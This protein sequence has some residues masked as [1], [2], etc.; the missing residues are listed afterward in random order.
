MIKIKKISFIILIL[1]ISLTAAAS[2]GPQDKIEDMNFRNADIVDVLRAIAEVADVNL[3][4]DSQVVGNIT[5][6]L[7][8]ITFE[9]SLDLITK[10]RGLDYKWDN[11][12]VVVAQPEK[13]DQIYSNLVTE[14][15]K[16]NSSDFENIG[17]IVKEIFPETLI[18]M[19]IS[20]RQFIIKGESNRVEE[21]K[22][23]INRLDSAKVLKGSSGTDFENR[24]SEETKLYSESYTVLNADLADLESKL[25]IVNSNLNFQVNPLTET[26]T[27]SG[28]EESVKSI[29]SMAKTYDQSLEPE[30]RKMRVDYID[31]AQITEIINK[32]YPDIQLH[33]NAKR[34]EIIINGAKN[35][36]DGVSELIKEINTPQYQ[37]IIETRVEEI[38]SDLTR[39]IGMKYSDSM[40]VGIGDIIIERNTDLDKIEDLTYK[41]PEIFK[42]LDTSSDSKTLARPSLMTLNGEEANLSITDKEPYAVQEE[43]DDGDI[44]TTW[45][46]VEA[47]VKLTFT[48]WITENDEIEL[49]IAPEVSSFYEI[50]PDRYS[51]IDTTPP[52]AT[53]T[54]SVETTLRLNNNETFVIGGLIQTDG[55]GTITKIPLLGDLPIFGEL[56]K[57][58]SK[59]ESTNELLI[60]VTPRIIKYGEEIENQD[61]IRDDNVEVD[62][63]TENSSAEKTKA[64]IINEYLQESG[65]ERKELLDS[66][67][68]NNDKKEK[69]FEGLTPEELE[70][71]LAN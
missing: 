49:K 50:N 52:P 26:I 1:V 2:A 4:T 54:R 24:E 22:E 44:T 25:R 13:I 3:I 71:I 48:P 42:L 8:D 45:E 67:R 53:K 62:S 32:F 58:R 36:L 56:F 23:M 39:E 18:S 41:W 64:E 6:H 7:Q 15:V 9:K 59:S 20:R 46:H 68:K 14:F 43:D 33:V 10:T 47:G 63:D 34:K 70:S 38:S 31:T 11:N 16:V 40:D 17:I 61:Y 28:E 21:I 69:E 27:I 12:T 60:F 66:L 37:V 65:K 5:V 30:T 57:S 51:N 19:D 55:E 29:L 35:K